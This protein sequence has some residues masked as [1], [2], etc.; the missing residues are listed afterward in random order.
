M[1]SCDLPD[2]SVPYRELAAAMDL[3]LENELVSITI[4][5]SGA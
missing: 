2:D 3:C 5:S 1:E 4:R